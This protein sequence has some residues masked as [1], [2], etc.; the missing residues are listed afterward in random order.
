MLDVRVGKNLSFWF[1]YEG[2]INFIDFSL[3]NINILVISFIDGF[4]CLWDVR[5]M[6]VKYF[7]FNNL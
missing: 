5:K 4:V 3:V 2:R 1:I 7:E 6:D